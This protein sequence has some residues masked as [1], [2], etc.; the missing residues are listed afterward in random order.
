MGVF[1]VGNDAFLGQFGQR[2]VIAVVDRLAGD[3]PRHG[4]AGQLQAAYGFEAQQVSLQDQV[5]K[6]F[7]QLIAEVQCSIGDQF[8]FNQRE[9][10]HQFRHQW[11]QPSVDHRVH[12]TDADAPDLAAGGFQGLLQPLH[13]HHHLL[14]VIEHLQTFRGE[15]HAA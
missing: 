12:R 15:A 4:V 10:V 5:E 8:N 11:A 14:G 3:D 2:R 7:L 6:A 13:G 9:M 1:R